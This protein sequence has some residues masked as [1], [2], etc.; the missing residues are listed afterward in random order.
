MTVRTKITALRK[1]T[2]ADGATPAEAKSAADLADAIERKESSRRAEAMEYLQ[3]RG[4]SAAAAA[5]IASQYNLSPDHPD[6]LNIARWRGGDVLD[7][8]RLGV[9]HDRNV[10]YLSSQLAFD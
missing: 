8:S 7:A 10:R 4:W 5:G 2:V 9:S 3:A 6:E 1:L